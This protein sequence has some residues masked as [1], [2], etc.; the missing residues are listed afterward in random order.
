[1]SAYMVD[2]TIIER[3]VNWM[4]KD[5]DFLTYGKYNAPVKALAEIDPDDLDTWQRLAIAIQ[6]MN[7][8]AIEQRYDLKTAEEM[9]A[10]VGTVDI[11]PF[12]PKD[13][14][15]VVYQHLRT[16]IY[17][18]SEGDVDKGK[19]FAAIEEVSNILAHRIARRVLERKRGGE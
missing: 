9:L 4:R 7:F 8:S 10:S 13:E 6:R 18:C 19:L 2:C 16:L 3:I 11:K 1:M 14:D 17:Q 12:A 5:K 15:W